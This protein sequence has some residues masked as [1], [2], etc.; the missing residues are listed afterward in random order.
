MSGLN[1]YDKRSIVDYK[2]RKRILKSQT[3]ETSFISVKATKI[4]LETHHILLEINLE[5]GAQTQ[6][7][8]VLL[9]PYTR[10]INT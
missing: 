8:H 5:L 7:L 3:H 10:D 9:P 4:L 2:E 1:C 6:V